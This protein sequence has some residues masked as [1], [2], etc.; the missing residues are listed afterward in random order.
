VS[1]DQPVETTVPLT[2]PREGIGVL[3]AREAAGRART[4]PHVRAAHRVA[5]ERRFIPPHVGR[6]PL[7]HEPARRNLDGRQR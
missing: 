2:V 1:A 6:A 3:A 7:A 5:M 4:R